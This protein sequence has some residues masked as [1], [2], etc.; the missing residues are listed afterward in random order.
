MVDKII[1]KNFM[2]GCGLARAGY[3]SDLL[4]PPSK[5]IPSTELNET[6]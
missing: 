1:G 5:P 3:T 4:D 2:A 6:H